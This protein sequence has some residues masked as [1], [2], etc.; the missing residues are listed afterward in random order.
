MAKKKA[1]TEVLAPIS[2]NFKAQ[3]KTLADEARGIAKSY[4][5]LTQRMLKLS[6]K[7]KSLSEQA[8]KLD[9]DDDG[10]HQRL[11]HD[12]IADAV[13]TTD[14]SVL[15]KYIT[16][17]SQA[18][19]LLTYKNDLPHQR[20]GLYEVALAV[21]DRKPIGKWIVA[22]DLTNERAGSVCL[23]NFALEISGFLPG[24]LGWRHAHLG[25]GA[26]RA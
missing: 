2:G 4:G 1:R 12:A 23:N 5:G 25:C 16:I 26:G 19:M 6:E 24:F 10:G 11:L 18:K 9:D 17:G 15:S 13:G 8:K 14:K 21:K 22:G 3:V 20:D 7:I